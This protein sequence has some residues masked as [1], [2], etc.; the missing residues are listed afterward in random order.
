MQRSRGFGHGVVVSKKCYIIPWKSKTKQRMVFWMIHVKD[1]L[2]PMGKV[3]SLDF[4]GI[5]WYQFCI[6]LGS[7]PSL[8]C[9]W[10][11]KTCLMQRSRGFGHGVVVSKK[12]YII[13]WY[14]F[15]IVLAS[16]P[17]LRCSWR[18][19][20]C[21]MQRSRGFG[22][23]VVVSKKCYIIYWYQFCIVLASCP[24]GDNLWGGSSQGETDTESNTAPK[25]HHC[26]SATKPGIIGSC[27]DSPHVRK[28]L[29]YTDCVP[30]C[31]ECCK[32]SF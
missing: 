26:Q 14:Q 2:L 28:L 15:C 6:V 1:S 20:T 31:H 17:S 9:S 25:C 29:Q 27:L 10:R 22:H 7:C 23:G 13:Y 12:C 19:K 8:R 16:C 21:L 5:Y 32:L 4:L 30:M 18:K 3:W 11:K 24:S